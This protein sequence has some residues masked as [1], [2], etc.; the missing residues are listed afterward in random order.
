MDE[1]GNNGLVDGTFSIEWTDGLRETAYFIQRCVTISDS[2]QKVKEPEVRPHI[3]SLVQPCIDFMLSLR[4]P[5]GNY[6]AVVG[7][8]DDRLV[9]WCHGA[10]GWV[11]MFALAYQARMFSFVT[12]PKSH[13][14]LIILN[15]G[16]QEESLLVQ[17]MLFHT[18][19]AVDSIGWFC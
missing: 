11:A 7:D 12:K 14:Y 17:S 3:E 8:S 15:K 5:S 13:I 10:P 18:Y 19:H 6:P 2:F 16:F 1:S 4:F 9:H